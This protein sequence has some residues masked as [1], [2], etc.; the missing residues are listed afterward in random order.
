MMENIGRAPP[1]KAER[2]EVL[3]HL[4]ICSTEDTRAGAPGMLRGS[5][6]QV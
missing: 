3:E 4:H 2:Q 5:A 1:T 6:A